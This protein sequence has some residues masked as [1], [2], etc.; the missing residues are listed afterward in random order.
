[1]PQAKQKAVKREAKA[2]RNAVKAA[3]VAAQKNAQAA[4]DKLQKEMRAQQAKLATARKKMAM[5]RAKAAKSGTTRDKDA[6][7]KAAANAASIAGRIKATR[8]RTAAAKQQ[9]VEV[10]DAVRLKQ[11]ADDLKTDISRRR[12]ELANRADADAK[13][14]VQAFESRWR[15]S[16][17]RQD[18]VKLKEAEKKAAARLKTAE[19]KLAEKIRTAE[20][21]AAAKLKAA[22]KKA[23]R[24]AV[25]I[26]NP[27]E[28]AVEKK[29]SARKVA[30]K[31]A[32]RKATKK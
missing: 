18:A 10:I 32:V 2:A 1:M 25:S 30:S 12:Q 29:K 15:K 6:H 24:P 20:K 31:K 3:G 26:R 9:L 14:A 28:A 16:R 7:K 13:K 4:V 19:R 17:A 23:P 21:Q 27:G 11:L 8:A 22:A 5:A